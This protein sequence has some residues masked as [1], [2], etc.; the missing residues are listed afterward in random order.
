MTMRKKGLGKG[1]SA[2]LGEDGTSGTEQQPVQ[3]RAV[4][5]VPVENLRPNPDQPRKNFDESELDALAR[6]VETQGILQPLLVRPAN[7]AGIHEIIAGERRWRAA[8]RARIHEV[9]VY[10]RDLEERVAREAMLIENVQRQDLNPIEEALGLK[11]LMDRYEYAQDQL[12]SAIGKSRSH[13]ANML[14][15]TKLPGEVQDFLRD[16]KMTI[17]QARPLIGHEHAVELARL[18]VAKELSVREVERLAKSD[19]MTATPKKNAIKTKSKDSDTRALEADLSAALGMKV[20]VEDS[21]RGHGEIRISYED[22]EALDQLCG[23]LSEIGLK[24]R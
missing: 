18:V 14:R 19:G 5:M 20:A 7:E 9:P 17:G 3:A 22:F 23:L 1:L 2:L 12:A 24:R 8:Q 15:L 13:I 10:I 6:S 11:D 21:G 16:G 4:N